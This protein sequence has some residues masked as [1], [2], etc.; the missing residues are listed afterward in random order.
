[1]RKLNLIFILMLN[2][3]ISNAQ[4]I[5]NGDF[6]DWIKS[7]TYEDPRFWSTP[8]FYLSTL[9]VSTVSKEVVSKYSGLYSARLENKEIL[10]GMYKI[11]GF[12]T[13]GSF[14]VDMTTLKTSIWGGIPFTN[15]PKKLKG[16]VNYSEASG[17]DVG[18]IAV[19]LFKYDTLVG[20]SD[21][22]AA[23]YLDVKNTNGWI[24]FDIWL[25]YKSYDTPDSM[26]IMCLSSNSLQPPIG[27][28][29]LIDSLFFDYSTEIDQKEIGKISY[30]ISGS[31]LNFSGLDD[32]QFLCS[33]YTVYGQKIAE[34]YLSENNSIEIPEKTGKV[35]IVN[36]FNKQI[37]YSIKI[38]RP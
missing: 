22:I 36:L 38:I 18:M 12:M 25:D 23:G 9:A 26:N 31:K 29:M 10:G 27:T 17:G 5:P 4:E 3:F 19:A 15:T 14:S 37:N 16:Y 33:I 1:M 6:E 11:P 13:L 2:F 7:T 24:M 35:F 8:N 28:I 30:C 32:G 21:T 20:K 34:N